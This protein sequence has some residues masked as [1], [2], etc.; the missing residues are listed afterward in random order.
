MLLYSWCGLMSGLI[1]HLRRCSGLK[2]YKFKIERFKVG[3][4]MRFI[5]SIIQKSGCQLWGCA[6]CIVGLIFVVE[7]ENI[8]NRF[9]EYFGHLQ[10]QHR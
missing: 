4:N 8:F 6:A 1:P 7:L 5:I 9:A 10:G 3:N 2:K